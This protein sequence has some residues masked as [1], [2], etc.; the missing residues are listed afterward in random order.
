MAFHSKPCPAFS[1]D[2]VDPMSRVPGL[3]S[4]CEL[5]ISA[6]YAIKRMQM[7]GFSVADLLDSGEMKTRKHLAKLQ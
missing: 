3:F 2:S 7:S 1:G 5:Q 4:S 6:A